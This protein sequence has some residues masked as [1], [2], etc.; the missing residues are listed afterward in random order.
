MQI[1]Q[2]YNFIILQFYNFI[3][4][5][6]YNFIVFG[7]CFIFNKNVADVKKQT[8]E[9]II[10]NYHKNFIENIF[11]RPVSKCIEFKTRLKS[12]KNPFN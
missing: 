7:S 5:Q 2:F 10:L 12:P 6:F 3:I 1:L 9:N 8:L 4:L 11:F